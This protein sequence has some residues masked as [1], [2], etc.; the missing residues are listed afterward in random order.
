MRFST[1]FA[2]SVVLASLASAAP[3]RRDETLDSLGGSLQGIVT[4]VHQLLS[5]T[6]GV[7]P[8]QLCALPAASPTRR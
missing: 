5:T 7:R 6:E 4:D 2:T 3:L 1:A 8:P